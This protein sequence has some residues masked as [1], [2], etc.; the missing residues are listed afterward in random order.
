MFTIFSRHGTHVSVTE[1]VFEE[2][3]WKATE[4]WNIIHFRNAN[5]T[6]LGSSVS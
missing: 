3:D 1:A 6:L 4:I 5:F 2:E